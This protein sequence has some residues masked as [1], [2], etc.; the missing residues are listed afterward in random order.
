MSDYFDYWQFTNE[1]DNDTCKRII[2]LGKD[3]WTK[4]TIQFEEEF[5]NHRKS[6]VFF[7]DEQWLYDMAYTQ[8]TLA[9]IANGTAWEHLKQGYTHGR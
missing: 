4:G 7:T 5:K 6:E 9:E 8:W 2:N 1:I 3:N